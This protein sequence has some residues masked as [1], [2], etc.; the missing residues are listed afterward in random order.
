MLVKI[1]LRDELRVD[2]AELPYPTAPLRDS[3]AF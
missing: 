3:L 1:R 2:L